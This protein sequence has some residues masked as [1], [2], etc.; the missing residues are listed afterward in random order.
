[1]ALKCDRYWYHTALPIFKVLKVFCIDGRAVKNAALLQG[2][3]L[4]E[5]VF[6]CAC[7]SCSNR[8]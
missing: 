8:A 7:P 2:V 5:F 6:L 4:R 1:M 3:S